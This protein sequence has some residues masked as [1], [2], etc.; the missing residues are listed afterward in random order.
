[1]KS[2]SKGKQKYLTR[3]K[4]A[5]MFLTLKLENNRQNF[6]TVTPTEF[7]ATFSSS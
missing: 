3:S 2:S 6:A 4:R 5:M 7:F 1:M